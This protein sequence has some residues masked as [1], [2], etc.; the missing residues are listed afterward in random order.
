VSRYAIA[1]VAV[2]TVFGLLRE[3]IVAGLLFGG[4]FMVWFPL[5]VE[6]MLRRGRGPRDD[7]IRDPGD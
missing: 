3:S 5:V 2:G 1:S 4:V 7:G 6:P